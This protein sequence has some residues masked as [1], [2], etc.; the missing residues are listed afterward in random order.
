VMSQSVQNGKCD[1][2]RV[3][4]SLAVDSELPF[5]DACFNLA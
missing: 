1:L 4:Q 5:S 2:F 3:N